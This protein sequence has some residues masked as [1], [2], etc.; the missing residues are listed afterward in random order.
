L[1]LYKE[2]SNVEYPELHLQLSGDI[3]F[4]FNNPEHDNKSFEGFE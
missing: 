4:P 3:H 2:Q 1:Q